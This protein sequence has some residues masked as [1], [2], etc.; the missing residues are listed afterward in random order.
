[1]NK[2]EPSEVLNSILLVVLSGKI[3][4]HKYSSMF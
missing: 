3:L 1:M 2:E 4:D